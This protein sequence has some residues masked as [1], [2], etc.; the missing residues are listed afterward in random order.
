MASA[1]AK[2]M[3]ET[4]HGLCTWHLLQNGVKYLRNLMKGGTFLL[5]DI[6]KCMYDIDN[7]SDFEKLWFDLINEYNIRDKPWIKSAYAIG[8]MGC[9]LY[10]GSVNTW[11][12]K[13]TT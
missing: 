11:H 1:L 13:Y 12:A 10:E 2:V 3:P 8:K 5:R 6:K 4:H 7:E 9:M